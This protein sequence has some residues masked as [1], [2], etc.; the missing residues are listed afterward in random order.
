MVAKTKAYI[1]SS[2]GSALHGLAAD[3][4]KTFLVL[5]LG[6]I[7]LMHGSVAITK[8]KKRNKF[9]NGICSDAIFPL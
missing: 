3:H 2:N 7:L 6:W 4:L 8:R 1:Y 9:T 5:W